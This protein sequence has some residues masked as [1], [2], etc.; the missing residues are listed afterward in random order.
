MDLQTGCDLQRSEVDQL[1]LSLSGFVR[2]RVEPGGEVADS[3]DCILRKQGLAQLPQIQPSEGSIPEGTVVEIEPIDVEVGNQRRALIKTETA[4]GG[5]LDP[6][7]ESIGV[8]RTSY[9]TSPFI[10]QRVYVEGRMRARDPAS[11]YR[12][13]VPHIE[14]A[15]AAVRS[16]R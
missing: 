11:R 7:V 15:H 14:Q 16:H 3:V 2:A 12:L 6:T 5:G 10:V 13:N 4:V 9:H 8:V 1:T